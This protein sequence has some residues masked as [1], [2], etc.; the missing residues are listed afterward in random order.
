MEITSLIENKIAKYFTIKSLHIEEKAFYF[1]VWNYSRENFLHLIDELDEIGY[2]P[3]IDEYD[4]TYRINIAKK[5][6][7]AKSRIHINAILF[8][9][10]VLSTVFVG[11]LWEGNILDGIVFSAAILAIVGTHETAHYLAAKKHDVKATLPYFIPAPNMI[12]TFGAVINIKSAIPNKNA[13]FDLGVSGP[14]AGFIVAVPVLIIGIYYSTIVPMSNEPVLLFYSSPIMS[15]MEYFITSVPD[16]YYMQLNPLILAGWV[17][18]VITML[19]LMPI[20]VL[21]GGHISRS[22]FSAKIHQ[23]IS[24]V[25]VIVMALLGWYLMAALL[26]GFILFM[27]RRHPGALDN[28]SKLSKNRKILA[29][30]MVIIFI[31]CLSPAPQI[32]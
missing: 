6:E 26:V 2:I 15:I 12:G 16:G 21:D 32:V 14:I 4:S 28:V 19:N 27:S 23:Y 1:D 10:T 13:L 11:Y 29:I 17:G 20:A 22:I 30:V 5:P 31:L 25:A 24:I 18:I 9:A 3:F 8:L 7:S